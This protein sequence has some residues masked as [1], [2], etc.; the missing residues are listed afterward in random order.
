MGVLGHQ[1][2]VDGPRVVRDRIAYF[3]APFRPGKVDVFIEDDF[4]NLQ[5][6]VTVRCSTFPSYPVRVVDDDRR[7]LFAR[8]DPFYLANEVGLEAGQY[9]ASIYTAPESHI[10]LGQE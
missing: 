5:K 3:I 9:L 1:P 2:P 7:R 6:V 10:Q 8:Q 4:V